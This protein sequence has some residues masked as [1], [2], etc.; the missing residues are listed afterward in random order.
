MRLVSLLCCA[1]LL[2]ACTVGP[3]FH[4][5][6][7]PAPAGYRPAAAAQSEVAAAG[8]PAG[9]RPR[10]GEGPQAQWWKAF[11]SPAL[12]GLVER[13][14]IHN[15]SLE[16]SNATLAAMQAEVRAAAGRRLPQV[17]AQARADQQQVNLAAFGFSGLPGAGPMSNPEFHLYSVGG[18]VFYNL[19][20]FG[21]LRR[22]VEQTG[23]RAEAQQHRTE[24]AHL[25]IAGQVVEQVLLIAGLSS[26]IAN[27]RALL[28][29][30]RR[31]VEL[32]ERKRDAGDGTLLDVLNVRS[33][34]TADQAL[35]PPLIQQRNAAI[36]LL[37]VLV[38][39]PPSDV[40]AMDLNLDQFRLPAEIPVT[41]PSALA[42]KRPDI[43]QAEA[44]LHAAIAEIGIAAA[45]LYPDITLGAT[46]TQGAPNV[47]DLTR[48]A[49]RGYDLFATLAAPIFHG[50]TL[51][52]QK[53]AAEERA[54]AAAAQYQETVLT[55]FRQV[56]DL[57][58]SLETDAQALGHQREAQSVA[59][60]SLAL[61]RRSF[62]VG[63]SGILQVLDSSRLHRQTSSGVVELRTRQ[64]V[65]VARLYAATAGGWITPRPAEG[66]AEA[67]AASA[68]PAG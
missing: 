19:D 48:N 61:S 36:H 67:G 40:E 62:E 17:D 6:Q 29:D 34:Y 33:Q 64:I 31:N 44:E 1:A 5:P 14:L 38:G 52:A 68:R 24:A 49:F 45:A 15:H 46:V 65:D 39:L 57:L 51:S 23:A 32:T 35:V 13:A 8:E 18:G 11:G 26:Q 22:R 43:L 42:G 4:R 12:D 50:G 47:D 56:A 3:D 54:R 30:D 66:R 37:A 25:A 41:L 7:P 53:R 58:S 16:A 63:N 59:A 55:A 60:R 10:P 20:P 2:S 21:G 28:E 27:S 9:P